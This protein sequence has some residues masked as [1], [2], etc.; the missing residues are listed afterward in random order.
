MYIDEI[1]YFEVSDDFCSDVVIKN[2]NTYC[3][4]KYKWQDRNE[5]VCLI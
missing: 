2:Y 3:G 4:K 1:I 5:R